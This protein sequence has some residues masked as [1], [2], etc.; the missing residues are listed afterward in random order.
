LA[1]AT[2]LKQVE[3]HGATDT[4]FFGR[5][6]WFGN[7]ILTR[8]PIEN[9]Q[10]VALAVQE[11]DIHLGNQKRE[12]V[13]PRAFTA[14]LLRLEE[15]GGFNDDDDNNNDS[16]PEPSSSS[17]PP[18]PQHANLLGIIVT[19][20]D[21]KSEELRVKQISR[22]VQ[23]IEA[24][25]DHVPQII[26]GDFNTFQKSDTDEKGWQRILD[27]YHSRGWPKPS[28]RSLVLEALTDDFGYHDTFYS[29]RRNNSRDEESSGTTLPAPTSWTTNP[30][31]RIDHVFF[32]NPT[33]TS[34]VLTTDTIVPMSHYRIDCDASDH[35]PVVCNIA[36]STRRIS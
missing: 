1:K 5:G 19:H 3:F 14:V 21:H 33:K 29:A 18:P 25:L 7:A 35:F 11:G 31:M 2:N 20:L 10:H 34:L 17:S 8:Y 4:S 12:S 9:C 30:L 24:F 36:C 28:E 13:D 6:T 22:G 32:K 27:L 26:C 15:N 16:Q 23:A